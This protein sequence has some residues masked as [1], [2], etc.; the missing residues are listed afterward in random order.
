MTRARITLRRQMKSKLLAA[1]YIA[2][3]AIFIIV[4]LAVVAWF[5]F[6]DPTTGQ[7]TLV[8]IKEIKTY[9]PTF[10]D[11]LWL[12]ALSALICL[13]IG[14]PV[15]YAVANM[16]PSRQRVMILL[17]ML[18]MCMSFLLRTLALVSILEDTGLINRMLSALGFGTVKLIR[19][20]G[21]VVLGMVYNYL[22]YMILPLYSVLTKI[23]KSH[24]EAAQDL[25]CGGGHVLTKVILPLSVPGIISG[26]TMVF[27]PA[28]ST[29]YISK[30]LGGTGT[31]MVGDIIESQFKA[32]Y[33]MN[34]GAAMSLGLMLIIFL[35]MWIMNKFTDSEEVS[36]I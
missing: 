28:V 3:M 30:K 10:A 12:A 1:P 16:S 6:T 8:N 7:L 26:V 22:P 4:P 25:G 24:I 23:N 32:S 2:W 33:N 14:Y 19:T 17:I 27:V 29:F 20:P 9:L 15:A 31:A 13:V 35:C 18:P 34:A 5:A 36:L 21:A 11:S